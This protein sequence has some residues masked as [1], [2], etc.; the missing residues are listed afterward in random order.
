MEAATSR[1]RLHRPNG[2]R[3]GI[4]IG[5]AL[6]FAGA[7]VGTATGAVTPFQLVLVKNTAAE[8]VPVTGTVSVG[9]TPANQNVTVSNFPATQPVSG[10]VTVGNVVTKAYDDQEIWDGGARHTYSFGGTIDVTS[11][12]TYTGDGVGVE[13]ITVAG[14]DNLVGSGEFSRE[15]TVPVPAT[16]VKMF[17]SESSDCTVRLVV[18]GH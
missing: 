9:N 5:L 8:P 15:F 2:L 18:F 12:S 6:A 10:S 11:L 17:C 3:G 1:S 16:G 7:A 13:L 4:V 14:G